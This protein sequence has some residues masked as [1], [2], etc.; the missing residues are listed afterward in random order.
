L[1]IE[2]AVVSNPLG[3]GRPDL[4]ETGAEA[5]VGALVDEDGFAGGYIDEPEA[6]VLVGKA[7]VFGV[8]RP[9]RGVEKAG[10]GS[11]IDDDRRLESGLVA[12]VKL[13]F[14]RGVGEVGDGLTV[15][16]P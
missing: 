6:K 15:R 4:A 1:I 10:V 16:A 8:G 7:D 12:Q 5:A 3:I 14:A 9:R 11:E 2:I 13:V